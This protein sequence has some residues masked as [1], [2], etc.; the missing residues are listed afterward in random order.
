MNDLLIRALRSEPV[1]RTPVWF[2]RQAG[3]SLPRYR[4]LKGGRD[5]LEVTRDPELAA[6]ITA[7]P[8]EYFPVDAA[9]LF[10]DISTIFVGAGLDVRI[11]KGLGP[12]LP[13]PFDSRGKIRALAPFDP[14]DTLDF[15]LETIR[16]LKERITVPVVGFIGA[17]FTLMTYLVESPRSTDRRGTKSLMWRE[18]GLWRELLSYW[19]EHLL[20][21]ARA[22]ARAG[23]AAIQLFDSWAGALAPDDYREH[24]LP[25]SR[26][27]LSGLRDAGVPSIH[28]ATG[29]PALLPHLAAAG[30]DAIGLDWRIEIDR[31]REILGPGVAVQGNLDPLTLLAGERT[32][33]ARA[34]EILRRVGGRPGHIFNVGHGIHPDTDPSVV[35]AVVDHVHSLDLAALR[36]GKDG[37][38][39]P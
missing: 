8:L 14:S 19:S 20:A 12:V 9:V 39:R 28:F 24:V 33:T 37:S 22:Q 21:F 4:E 13:E 29:N 15:V 11:R 34:E 36:G 30:G 17:P 2:M 6:R 16:R 32:A 25:H 10:A 1:E 5:L 35:K 7:L 3:R 26:R 27:I 31:A 38:D 23:A 18:P